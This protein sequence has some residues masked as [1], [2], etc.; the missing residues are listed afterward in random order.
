MGNN[1]VLILLQQDYVKP[2]NKYCISIWSNDLPPMTLL[3]S[4]FLFLSSC[5]VISSLLFLKPLQFYL[6]CTNCKLA[7]KTCP[8]DPPFGTRF[9][10]TSISTVHVACLVFW[11]TRLIKVAIC[12]DFFFGFSSDSSAVLFGNKTLCYASRQ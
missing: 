6:C 11:C 4:S 9:S 1:Y 2:L 10:N 8:K 3:P 5:R 7:R 12:K